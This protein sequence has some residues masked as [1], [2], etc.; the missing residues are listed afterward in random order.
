MCFC[1]FVECMC[2]WRPKFDIGNHLQSILLTEAGSSNSV[3]GD[4]YLTSMQIS[5]DLN[6]DP[7]ACV[8]NTLMAD[9]SSQTL[10]N[11]KK[12]KEYFNSI[13]FNL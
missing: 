3:L 5:E 9:S 11:L 1:M 6:L 4:A 8:T 10:H 7:Q 2:M 12:V 13:Q